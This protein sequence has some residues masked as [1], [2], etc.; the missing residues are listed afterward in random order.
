M[1]ITPA[2]ERDAAVVLAAFRAIH[3]DVFAGDSSVN[4][5]LEVEVLPVGTLDGP[6]GEQSVL[7]LITPWTLN[8]L[9]LPG[10]GLPE[11]MDVAGQQRALIT[12]ELDA[13][14]TYTQVNLVGDVSRY[15]SQEQARTIATSMI[16]VLWAGLLPEPKPE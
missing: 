4:A 16:P 2:V 7:I 14:G 1:S 13:I 6:F 5:A 9:V 11:S 12:M 15:A 10:R 3:D 8:G